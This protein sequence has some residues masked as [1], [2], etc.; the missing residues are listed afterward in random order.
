[1]AKKQTHT[2]WKRQKAKDAQLIPLYSGSIKKYRIL[3]GQMGKLVLKK[4]PI[5][6]GRLALKMENLK[7]SIKHTDVGDK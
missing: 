2:C 5:C 7:S 6:E 4:K 1:M 3:E